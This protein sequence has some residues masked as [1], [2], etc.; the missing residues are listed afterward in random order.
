MENGC[1]YRSAVG[2]VYEV[3]FQRQGRNEDKG[4]EIAR[5]PVDKQVYEYSYVCDCT[6]D[7]CMYVLYF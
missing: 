4:N 3:L 7:V 6:F 1:Q 2:D 5:P